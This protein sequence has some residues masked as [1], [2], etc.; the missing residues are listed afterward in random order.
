[1]HR[2]D[3]PGID[4]A[5]HVL[6]PQAVSDATTTK[7]VVE[8]II[9]PNCSFTVVPSLVQYVSNCARRRGFTAPC[10]QI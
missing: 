7:V 10:D 2:R 8:R 1:M 3:P 9:R 5:K 4:R 6:A